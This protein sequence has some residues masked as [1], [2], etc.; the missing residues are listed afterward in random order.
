MI[1]LLITSFVGSL[2]VAATVAVIR[3][4]IHTERMRRRR[5]EP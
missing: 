1:G 3:E 5:R 2:A 4:I